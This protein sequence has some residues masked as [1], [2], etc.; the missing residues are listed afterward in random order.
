MK[1]IVVLYHR[2]CPDGFTSAYCAWKKFGDQ[3]DYIAMSHGQ[4]PPQGLEGKEVYCIDYSFKKDILLDLEKKVKRLIVLDHHMGAREAVEAVHEHVFDNDRSGAGIAWRYFHP[5]ASVPRLVDYVE[6]NDINK[7]SL[8]NIREITTFISIQPFDFSHFDKL[9]QN[10]ETEDGFKNIVAQGGAY[11]A[12]LASLCDY[13]ATKAEEVEID[14][15]RVF[16]VNVQGSQLVRDEIGHRLSAQ[17]GRPFAIIWCEDSK[18]RGFSLRG[19]GS[20]DLSLL[21]QKYGGNGHK[22]AASFRLPHGNSL[23]FTYLE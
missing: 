13:L 23:P 3:A 12:Y 20:V 22:G 15:H 19:D 5:D 16:A 17:K 8:T 10:I 2:N 4:E 9:A 11:L 7:N 14:G 18:G 1:D 6:D 21:A